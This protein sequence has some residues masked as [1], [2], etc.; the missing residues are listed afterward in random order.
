MDGSGNAGNGLMEGH[1]DLDD[2]INF[3][4]T[5]GVSP[6]VVVEPENSIQHHE[7]Q[8]EPQLEFS[9]QPVRR[10]LCLVEVD[11][12]IEP[13]V[14]MEFDSGEAAKTFYI[15]YA[16]KVGFSVRI[17]RSRRSKCN[18]SIIMLRFVCSKEGF[19]REKRIIAGKKTRKRAA[20]IRE[21]CKAMLEVIRRGDEK[22]VVT[23]LIKEHN[24][25]VGMPSKVHYIATE[26][27]AELVPYVGME[28]E[29]LEMAK[30][31]YYAYASR[32]GF[33]ARVRQSRRSLHDESLKMLKLVCSKHRYHS[34][35]DENGD[36]GRKGLVPD[37]SREGCNALF[38]IV[39]KDADVW[40]VSKLELD[41]THELAPSPHSKVRCVRSQGEILVIAKNFSDTRNL[42]LSSQ[43]SQGYP[44]EIRY[45]DL[46]P[47]DAQ[48]LL[49][50][51]KKTQMD[52]PAFF[53]ALQ[54]EQN[55]CM[56]NIFWADAKA[57]MAYHYFGDS[58][59]L[60]FSYKN[61]KD[62]MPLLLFTGVNHHLQ[63]VIFGCALLV[64]ESEASFI[65]LFEQWLAA[66]L[67]HYPVSLVSI[68]SWA[69]ANA[70][71]KVLPN[72]RLIFCR[73]HILST[74][75][76]E[77]PELCES[78]S[79]FEEEL[80]GCVEE[81]RT[82]ELFES[83]WSSIINKYDLRDNA[84]FRS[85]FGIRDKWVPLYLR[86]T[87][88]VEASASLRSETF[89]KVVEK[90]CNAKS[91]LRVAVRQ[92]GQSIA[93]SCEKEAQA[94]YI[95]LFEKP[96][97]RTASPMEKQA[98]GIY[99][100]IMFEKFQE[101]F[102][103]SLGYHVDKIEDGTHGKYQVARNEDVAG[104][105]TV[106]FNPSENKAQC[107]CSMFEVSGILCRHVLRV[108][109]IAGVRALPNEYILKRWMKN[110]KS[111]YI[112]EEFGVETR[113]NSEESSAARYADLYRD[114]VR[115][116]KEGATSPELYCVAKEAIQKAIAEVVSAKQ[117]R[118]EQILQSFKRAQKKG[119][120][121]PAKATI[122]KDDSSKLLKMTTSPEN[123]FR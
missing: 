98:S 122:K 82:I 1:V 118:G 92:F 120:K 32:M 34:G 106:T 41:H 85:L 103:E 39:R 72:T 53:Y 110:A 94:D 17:A 112:F 104:A 96:F 73:K 30:T 113:A 36:D 90:Y 107:S 7:Q 14:G 56:T 27:D 102:V 87:F 91:P 2:N 3:W 8:I 68:F 28:F 101:E 70:A 11:P 78:H 6:H 42:L 71:A 114:A 51:F 74:L 4:A 15:A 86:D 25:E 26:G 69:I 111:A 18:E 44:R 121:K 33:E 84:Y 57:R 67:S 64:D 24:H 77:L 46:G 79:I 54:Y 20:S 37:P 10:E 16:G 52:N 123:D 88:C 108:F 95:T 97:L 61:N 117:K 105:Y 38:E 65:W 9:E 5:F 35:R 119:M 12:R 100:R 43:D 55:N 99:T 45:N 76:D 50:Y 89:D 58:V 29:S 93:N 115:C 23:K 19:S 75:L 21:G 48:N 109:M 22:W 81:C 47:E 60:D 83:R 59:T 80:T 66:M 62:F 13:Y 49:E 116:A 63:P 31:F 40:M